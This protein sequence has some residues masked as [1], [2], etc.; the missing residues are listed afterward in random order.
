ME[1]I[2]V[3]LYS[4]THY[5]YHHL[6][7]FLVPNNEYSYLDTDICQYEYREHQIAQHLNIF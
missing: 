5:N 1:K 6:P 3:W 4:N 7:S 2:G